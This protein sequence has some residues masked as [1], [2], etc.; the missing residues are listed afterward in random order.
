MR[1]VVSEES[2]AKM[3]DSKKGVLNPNYGKHFSEDHKHK[4]SESNRGQKRSSKTCRNIGLSKE[5]PVGQFTISGKLIA[6]WDSGKKA[7]LATGTQAGH[8]S[9]VCKHKR[10]TAGG[11]VWAYM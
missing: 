4:I 2:R 8:I 9:K 7:A 11:Y 6:T 3:S 5:K 1:Y 10:K